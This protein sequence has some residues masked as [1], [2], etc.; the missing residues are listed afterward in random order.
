MFLRTYVIFIVLTIC[1]SDPKTVTDEEYENFYQATYKDFQKPL[2]W[3]HFSGDSGSGV[4]FRAII[5]VPS[6]LYVLKLISCTEWL[7]DMVSTVTTAT[8]RIRWIA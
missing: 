6:R 4:S 5:Y 3:Y 7:S 2:A 1:T 8:G